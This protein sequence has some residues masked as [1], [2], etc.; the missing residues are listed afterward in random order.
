M[1]LISR[2]H[3]AAKAAA[4]TQVD[5]AADTAEQRQQTEKLVAAVA[6]FALASAVCWIYWYGVLDITNPYVPTVVAALAVLLA[7]SDRLA[8]DRNPGAKG[9]T[10]YGPWDLL[11]ICGLVLVGPTWAA[12]ATL[13]AAIVTGGKDPLR[14]LYEF[15]NS[16][17]RIYVAALPFSLFSAPLLA[18]GAP[19]PFHQWLGALLA[20]TT[21]IIISFFLS[22]LPLRVRYKSS[23]RQ[24]LRD[25][26]SIFWLA[27]AIHV[28]AAAFA[29][30]MLFWSSVTAAILILF[31]AVVSSSFAYSISRRKRE[32]QELTEQVASLQKSSLLANSPF[33]RMI[34][35]QLGTADGL[36]DRHAAATAV[37]ASDLC[38]ELHGDREQADR[39]WSAGFLHNI[40]LHE[41][42][43][44]RSTWRDAEVPEHPRLGSDIISRAPGHEDIARWVLCH[45]ERIDGKGYPSGIR[46][47]WIPPEARMVAVAQ[48]YAAAILDK[49]APNEEPGETPEAARQML[50]E[51]VNTQFDKRIARRFV[52][53]LDN[54]AP[55]Y[56]HAT[57]QRFAPPSLTAEP[58]AAGH[59]TESAPE[60]TDA[61][62]PLHSALNHGAD[63]DCLT[64]QTRRAQ[65][66]STPIIGPADKNDRSQASH[67]DKHS[68]HP[69]ADGEE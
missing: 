35:T 68:H 19:T 37:Y 46:E 65:L 12:L 42:P 34:I 3:E 63:R 6:A 47:R 7:I 49:H 14:M 9:T 8:I 17:S 16:A 38:Y 52:H 57:T 22:M 50:L 43:R 20:A 2:I 24:Q 13:P 30:M 40:G 29:A 33:A 59:Q 69:D 4:T 25:T 18:G 21:L 48:A 15:S 27:D 66:R 31:A 56:V 55:E 58:L 53:M 54:A 39:V 67:T 60:A 23:F 28:L 62:R 10:T 26:P 45:H 51:N 32:T 64:L 61:D 1:S 44:K 41:S 11:E 36:T 5:P